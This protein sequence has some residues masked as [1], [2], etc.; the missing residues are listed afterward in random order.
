MSTLSVRRPLSVLAVLAMVATLLFA[1]AGTASAATPASG[2]DF[3]ACPANADIPD[4]GFTDTTTSFA[5]DD[6]DCIA[7]YAV[8]KGTTPTTYDPAA[9]VTRWQMALF[10]AR[11]AGPSGVVLDSTPPSAG[12]TDIGDLGPLTQDAINALADAGIV[13]GTSATTYSPDSVV[14]RQQMALFLTRFLG[15]AIVGPG[16]TKLADAAKTGSPF[17]DIG[18]ATFEANVAINQVWDLEVT[19]GKTATTYA[20]L[21][22]VTREQM[23]AFMARLMG[24]TNARPAGVNIQAVPLTGFGTFTA[25]FSVTA[26]N[27]D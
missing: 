4:P 1:V 19:T 3:A 18:S 7:Y 15:D 10:L 26:R 5:K 23:A 9:P 12:F 14:S 8:T 16:G 17:T 11:M 24:H 20:P 22:N 21:G 13:K 2:A 6:I 25:D 27:A